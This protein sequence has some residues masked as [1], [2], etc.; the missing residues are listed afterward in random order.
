MWQVATSHADGDSDDWMADLSAAAETSTAKESANGPVATPQAQRI[1]L[2][3]QVQP[4]TVNWMRPMPSTAGPVDLAPKAKAPPT[5]RG[6][7]YGD[8]DKQSAMATAAAQKVASASEAAVRLANM[9]LKQMAETQ[10]T[11]NKQT[12][13]KGQGQKRDLGDAA[14]PTPPPQKKNKNK[15]AETQSNE[16]KEEQSQ[17]PEEHTEGKSQPSLATAEV[18]L[19]EDPAEG[20]ADKEDVEAEVPEEG[21]N[22]G[23]ASGTF[24]GYRPPKKPAALEIFEYKKNMFFETRAA[25]EKKYPGKLIKLGRTAGQLA[26]WSHMKTQLELAKGSGK[27]AMTKVKTLAAIEA[28]GKTWQAHLGKL[29][30]A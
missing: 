4:A 17:A 27:P 24:A 29:A 10:A 20:D 15:A 25:L 16:Q 5:T 2:G 13:T 23:N 12:P 11:K 14:T 3:P 1:G 21:S 19:Q 22:K 26:W 30:K 28:A 8:W 7:R 6:A 9:A 18:P